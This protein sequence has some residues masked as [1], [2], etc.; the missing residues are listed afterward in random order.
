MAYE[1]YDNYINNIAVSPQASW[2]NNH[3]ELINFQFTNTFDLATIGEEVTIG[4]QSFSDIEVRLNHI[5]KG[6]TSVNKSKDYKKIIFKDNSKSINTGYRYQFDGFTWL[7][8]DYDARKYNSNSIIVRRC[9]HTLSWYNAEGNLIQEPS[10]ID[11]FQYK[12]TDDID[13]NKYM[14]VANT[15]RY[16][17]LQNNEYTTNLD[18]DRRFIFNRMAWRIINFDEISEEG[19]IQITVER[20]ESDDNK[21][22]IDTNLAINTYPIPIYTIDIL[23]EDIEITP[24]GTMQIYTEVKNDGVVETPSLTYASSDSN[25]ATV[26]ST[27]LVTGIINGSITLTVSLSDNSSI[28]DTITVDVVTIPVTN[29]FEDII[30]DDEIAIGNTSTYAIYKYIDGIAQI[31]TYVFTI[32]NTLVSM[33]SSTDNTVTLLSGE[34]TGSVILTAT[35][36][37]TSD[38]INKTIDITEAW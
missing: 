28:L 19:I 17:L 34:D 8:V 11:Y 2:K 36:D 1:L 23:N 10:V 18:Y 37:I 27:G 13:V 35:N 26:S 24:V 22:N 30:G 12:S 25:I 20:V 21:D 33:S 6:Y 29:T 15:T 3:Q 38:V 5:I 7:A 31:D 4:T 32:N 9:N 16:I 14:T